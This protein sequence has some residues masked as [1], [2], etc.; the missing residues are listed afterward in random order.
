MRSQVTPDTCQAQLLSVNLVSL[1]EPTFHIARFLPSIRDS[2]A[3]FVF[4]WQVRRNNLLLTFNV[5]SLYAH[6][7]FLNCCPCKTY[8]HFNLRRASHCKKHLTCASARAIPPIKFTYILCT[9]L[10]IYRIYG[11]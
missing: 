6:N 11:R 1:K 7:V 8:L 10:T 5:K 9:M 4:V 2:K 3:P